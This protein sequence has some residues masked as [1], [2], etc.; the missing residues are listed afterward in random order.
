MC[1]LL[2]TQQSDIQEL[3]SATLDWQ[4]AQLPRSRQVFYSAV[5]DKR[6]LSNKNSEGWQVKNSLLNVV[7]LFWVL[8]HIFWSFER[9]YQLLRLRPQNPSRKPWCFCYYIPQWHPNLH[10]GCW[11]ELCKSC[12]VG[13]WRSLEIRLV[14][15]PKRVSFLLERSSL[16][17][18]HHI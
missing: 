16:Y 12:L 10:P 11:P 6:I 2:K 5:L 17:R 7:R 15:Q 3:L 8:G 14:C 4:V 1:R 9:P 18:L 13:L